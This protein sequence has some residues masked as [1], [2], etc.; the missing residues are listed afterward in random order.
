M[1]V[2]KALKCQYHAALDML[3]Q[4][5]NDCPDGLWASGDLPVPFWQVVY[6][7]LYF[8]HLYLCQD[9]ESFR[10]WAHHLEIRHD[11]NAA[12]RGEPYTRGQLLDYWQFC[13]DTVDSAIDGM[14]LDAPTCGF[15][16]YPLPKLD[17]QINNIRHIQ[18]HA[19][20]LSGRLRQA[21][22]IDVRWVGP[23]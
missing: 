12:T 13:S 18:H 17:H 23:F 1:K 2:Q 8:T 5:I 20:L 9:V 15:P 22:G 16:W 19:A 3:K 10:P 21:A 7:T 4:A 11:L 6:H 14:D